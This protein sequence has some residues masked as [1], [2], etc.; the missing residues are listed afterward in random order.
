MNILHTTKLRFFNIGK[1]GETAISETSDYLNYPRP[2]FSIGFI[3]RGKGNFSVPN[4]HDTYVS[5]GDIIIVPSASQYISHISGT[6]SISYITF[7]FIFE[8]EKSVFNAKDIPIQKISCLSQLQDKF[9]FAYNNF[10]KDLSEQFKVMSVFYEVLCE[11]SPK[12]KFSPKKH[13]NYSIKKAIDFITSNYKSEITVAE[14]ATVANLSQSRFFSVFKQETG[15]TPIE[16][17]NYICIR[18]AEKMLVSEDYSIEEL[19]EKLGFNSS[20]YFRRTFRAYTGKSPR[21]YKNSIKSKL[22]VL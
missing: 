15:M 7:H 14:L 17:K 12:L 20:S 21:E 8:D 9:E 6:P 18:N 16:Y 1:Y 13:Q 4:S 2:F 5:P 22:K 19:S 3:I 10:N 11:I